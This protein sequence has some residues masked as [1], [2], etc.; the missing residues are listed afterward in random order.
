MS[1]KNSLSFKNACALVT[2][3]D[4][5]GTSYLVHP[6]YLLTCHH[7]VRNTVL[8][9]PVDVH[10]EHGKHEARVH[11]VD[12]MLDAALLRLAVPVTNIVPLTLSSMDVAKGISFESYGFPSVTEYSGL[13]IDGSVLDPTAQD[14]QG[15]PALTLKSDALIA[16]GHPHGL[17]G[18]PVL[19]NSMVI[20]HLKKIIADEDSLPQLGVFYASPGSLLSR[21]LQNF[22]IQTTSRPSAQPPGMT[23]NSDWYVHREAEEQRAIEALSYGGAAV[24][25]QAPAQFGKTWFLI[26]LISELEKIG[27]V[28]KIDLR[29]F[30][31]VE[32]IED[33]KVFIREFASQLLAAVFNK[34]DDEI[35][36]TIDSR[37]SKPQNPGFSL[38]KLFQNEVL[39]KISEQEFF[40]ILD[41]AQELARYDYGQEFFGLLR[42]WTENG[43]KPPWSKLRLIMTLSTA[44]AQVVTDINQSPFNTALTIPLDDFN[45]L[46]TRALANKYGLTWGAD[47]HRIVHSLVGGHPFLIRLVMYE[48]LLQK[49]SVPTLV[50]MNSPIFDQYLKRLADKL[51]KEK[52]LA[53]PFLKLIA[54]PK[55]IIP[56]DI[57]DRLRFA[58]LIK[59]DQDTKEWNLRYPLYRRLAELVQ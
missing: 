18:S 27:W 49:S 39:Q 45:E 28:A 25:I 33:Y 17:S 44:I 3:G 31:A 57:A 5:R 15:Q 4:E 14:P 9:D 30:A 20:G 43:V 24:V 19:A 42:S 16:G 56:S 36:R 55:T 8:G 2:A 21:L 52:R 46:Q 53:E 59:Y 41:G 32:H 1:A 13:L 47:D 51:K 26:N 35:M 34:D 37:L 58:G 48:V 22:G 40:L 54:T 7:V 11:A 10:F 12:A 23:Y 6:N 29:S 50:E 38:S